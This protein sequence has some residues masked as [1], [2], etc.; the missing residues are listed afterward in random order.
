[1]DMQ[2]VRELDDTVS[3]YVQ[4]RNEL[5]LKLEQLKNEA[6]N[7]NKWIE[8]ITRTLDGGKMLDD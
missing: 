6:V 8:A 3:R 2:F 5:Q 1:M 7:V 4:V